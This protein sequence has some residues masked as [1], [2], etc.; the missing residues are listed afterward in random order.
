MAIPV[1]RFSEIFAEAERDCTE[2]TFRVSVLH[3]SAQ[4]PIRQTK[5]LA[6][7]LRVL[8]ENTDGR[9]AFRGATDRALVT[10]GALFSF[11]S[12]AKRNEFIKCLR[13]YLDASSQQQ[14]SVSKV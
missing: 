9:C 1:R 4:P 3:E 11:T 7:L 8:A 12:D 5:V 10:D 6:G 2:H 13:L 14:L